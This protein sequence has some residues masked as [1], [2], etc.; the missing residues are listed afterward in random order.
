[1]DLAFNDNPDAQLWP[2]TV[3]LGYIEYTCMH[4]LKND[5]G[6]CFSFE[7]VN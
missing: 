3:A 6:R 7:H 1:M 2:A 5:P 4:R